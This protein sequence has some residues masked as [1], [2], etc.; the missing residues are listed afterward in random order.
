VNAEKVER[1]IAELQALTFEELDTIMAKLGPYYVR[2]AG[3]HEIGK[4]KLR[5]IEGGRP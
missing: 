2:R 5:V 3:Q 1:L 4:E